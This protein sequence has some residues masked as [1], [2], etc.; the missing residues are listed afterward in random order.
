MNLILNATV[1]A[2][3]NPEKL[4]S[5]A[6][7]VSKV[8][9]RGGQSLID[10]LGHFVTPEQVARMGQKARMHTVFMGNF[11]TSG[12]TD[13]TGFSKAH[14]F[15]G[16]CIALAPEQTRVAFVDAHYLCGV[17]AAGYAAAPIPGVSRARL[18]RFIGRAGAAGTITTRTSST[19]GVNG[20]FDCLGVTTKGD[21]HG[22]N[23]VNRGIPFLVAYAAA[24]EAMTDGNLSLLSKDSE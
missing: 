14:A 20:L 8:I 3:T 16:A 15:I 9:A 21:K 24:L 4:G 2:L 10:F 12:S 23:V 5:D 1:S 11:I 13:T 22:F 17:S 6:G 7:R 18:Q 19:V